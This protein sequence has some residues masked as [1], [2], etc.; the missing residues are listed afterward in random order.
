M[1]DFLNQLQQI[2]KMGPLENVIKMLPGI[3]SKLPGDISIDE[4]Q[5]ARPEAIIRSMT[6]KERKKPEIIN[7]SRKVRIANGAGV[8]VS[9]VNALLKQFEQMRS[10]VKKFTSPGGKKK[11]K[12][13]KMPF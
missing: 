12:R 6:P 3:G 13:M 10:M 9:D 7:A 11:F 8:K 1:E 2:K 5:L 4:K